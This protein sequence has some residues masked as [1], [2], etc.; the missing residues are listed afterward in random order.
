VSEYLALLFEG[1][2]AAVQPADIGIVVFANSVEMFELYAE[3][4]F[5]RFPGHV[6]CE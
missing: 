3:R 2:R 6:S 4:Q 5:H 1:L